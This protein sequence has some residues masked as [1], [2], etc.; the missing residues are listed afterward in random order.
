MPVI[1]NNAK[2]IADKIV[3]YLDWFL[4]ESFVEFLLTGGSCLFKMVS[5]K[6]RQYSV[7]FFHQLNILSNHFSSFLC[8]E[9][10]SKSL[11]VRV[12]VCAKTFS[13]AKIEVTN[14]TFLQLICNHPSRPITH[15]HYQLQNFTRK[16]FVQKIILFFYT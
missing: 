14:A 11:S 1:G 3:F 5:L 10:Q 2:K 16:S 8:S 12:S 9:G 6:K 7:H 4:K 13:E 15:L